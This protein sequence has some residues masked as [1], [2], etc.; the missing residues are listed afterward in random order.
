MMERPTSEFP[1]SQDEKA[2]YEEVKRMFPS[3]SLRLTVSLESECNLERCCQVLATPVRRLIK[4]QEAE[5]RDA[6]CSNELML[7]TAK[8]VM[9]ALRFVVNTTKLS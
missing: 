6:I 1:R 5:A 2:S 4:A 7:G 8:N 3:C 9:L